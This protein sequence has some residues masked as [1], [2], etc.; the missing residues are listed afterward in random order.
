MEKVFELN[1]VP[2]VGLNIVEGNPHIKHI[3]LPNRIFYHEEEKNW[4]CTLDNKRIRSIMALDEVITDNIALN[5][6]FI[7]KHDLEV[8]QQLLATGKK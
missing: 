6:H 2:F 7:D 5:W 4:H 3:V 8:Y 1:F